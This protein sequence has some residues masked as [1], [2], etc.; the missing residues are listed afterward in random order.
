MSDDYNEM[1]ERREYELRETI[2]ALAAKHGQKTIEDWL[3]R[4]EG[5]SEETEK[6]CKFKF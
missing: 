4:F 3:K 1:A 6:T 2:D 5:L